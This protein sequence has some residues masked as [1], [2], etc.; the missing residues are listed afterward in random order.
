[1]A[2]IVAVASIA[3]AA[4]GRFGTKPATRSPAATPA[5]RRPPATRA[6]S[7]RSSRYERLRRAPH[8]LRNTRASLPSSKRR[9]FSAKLRRACGKMRAA[10]G[11]HSSDSGATFAMLQRLVVRP[12]AAFGRRPGDDVVRV[13]DVARLAVHAVGGVDLQPPAARAVVHHLVDARRAEALAGIAELACAAARADPRVGHLEVH[14]LALLVSVAGEEHERHAIARRERALDPVTL[15][16]DELIEA[17][18]ARPVGAVP[19]RPG[20]MAADE[21]FPGGVDEPEPEILLERRLEVA[22]PL[23]LASALGGAPSGIEAPAA[24]G[25]GDVLAG[26][27]PGADRLVHAL[28]LG[29]V[30]R[31]ARI[32]DEDRARHLER[33][34]RLPA[35]GRDG[36]R[37]RREDL[38]TLEERLDARVVLVLLEGLEGLEPRIAVV[39]AHDIAD[40]HAGV[41]GV[42]G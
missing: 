39:E 10:E 14:R 17:L 2:P 32:A 23:E 24:P 40:V 15:G 30:E 31:P 33:R 36:A 3:I 38:P 8:S 26:E 28:D 22:D 11:R 42:I 7:P 34:R 27:R 37:P 1:M 13:L 18:E 19:E 25:V 35:A 5:A 41:G 21:G 16:G 12:R 4:S 20:R 29:E 9:R 6:T